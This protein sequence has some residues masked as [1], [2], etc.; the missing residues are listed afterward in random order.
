MMTFIVR[1]HCRWGCLKIGLDE[2]G[3]L[4]SSGYVDDEIWILDE[5]VYTESKLKK[6]G[7]KSKELWKHSPIRLCSNSISHFPK[8]P[9]SVL[10]PIRNKDHVFLF[11]Q[12]CNCLIFA[13]CV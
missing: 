2:G 9:L 11:L 6:V 8:L 4:S 13:I 12:S 1:R 5:K 3:R 10:I 7:E